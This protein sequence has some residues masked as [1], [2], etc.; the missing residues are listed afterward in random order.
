MKTIVIFMTLIVLLFTACQK[1]VTPINN[2]VDRNI[3]LDSNKS[4]RTGI[5][6][7]VVTPVALEEYVE[8]AQQND[9][10]IKMGVANKLIVFKSERVLVLLNCE[11]DVLSRH[12]VSL[13]ENPI[14]TKL[15][16][17]DHKTPEGRYSVVDMRSDPKYYK[18]ILISYP[19][20]E[21]RQRSREM[22]FNPGGGITIHAQVPWNWNGKGDDY[23][24][25][26][27][28]TSGCVALTNHGMDTIWQMVD[29]N[30][31]IDIRE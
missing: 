21:D 1:K 22:G 23:T 3:S 5:G 28:W 29:K 2:T 16:Q 24:L 20:E 19:N 10:L 12:K 30:T 14:G 11:G 4:V 17:G 26:K 15:Q 31:I 6:C 27:D 13:G 25:T 8:D 9:E 7:Y 18:E